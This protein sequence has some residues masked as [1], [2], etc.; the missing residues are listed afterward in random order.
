MDFA[1]SLVTALASGAA[2]T[3]PGLAGKAL[4]DAYEGLKGA[5]RGKL[6]TLDRLTARPES[7]SAQE[8]AREEIDEAKIEMDEAVREMAEKLISE[9]AKLPPSSLPQGMTVDQIRAA[10]D[11]LI[12]NNVGSHRLTKLESAGGRIIVEHNRPN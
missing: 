3:L 10:G 5:L 7:K 12:R 11:I 2:A 8:A 1:S 9:L 6:T 4:T